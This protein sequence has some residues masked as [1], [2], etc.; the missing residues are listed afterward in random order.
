MA[1]KDLGLIIFG[2]LIIGLIVA[3]V[4]IPT[5]AIKDLPNSP[6]LKIEPTTPGPVPVYPGEINIAPDQNSQPE[7]MVPFYL[8]ISE[9]ET[10]TLLSND[11][12]KSS[13]VISKVPTKIYPLNNVKSV[14]FNKV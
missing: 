6:S 4:L 3:F 10:L 13:Y 9:G 8:S 1:N 5:L 14:T 11:T 7:T 12:I 2:I